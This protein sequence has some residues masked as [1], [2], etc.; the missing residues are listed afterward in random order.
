M[1]KN[2]VIFFFCFK[3][4]KDFKW[5]YLILFICV[6]FSVI[7]GI[8]IKVVEFEKGEVNNLSEFWIKSGKSYVIFVVIDK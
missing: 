1:K 2:L 6:V 3:F 7:I 4:L 8:V 5:F